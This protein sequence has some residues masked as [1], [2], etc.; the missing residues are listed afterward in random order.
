MILRK[1]RDLGEH[2]SEECVRTVT[3]NPQPWNS[4]L[5]MTLSGTFPNLISP[6][7]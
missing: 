6:S 5:E 2:T 4:E 3:N 1:P 7:L